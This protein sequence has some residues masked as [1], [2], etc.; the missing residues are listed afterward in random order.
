MERDFFQRPFRMTFRYGDSEERA[1]N[2]GTFELPRPR[3]PDQLHTP[4]VTQRTH[5]AYLQEGLSPVVCPN[6]RIASRGPDVPLVGDAMGAGGGMAI[7]TT[8]R[9]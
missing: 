1:S 8:R 4:P 9:K 3:R 6:G 2:S 7:I 5:G